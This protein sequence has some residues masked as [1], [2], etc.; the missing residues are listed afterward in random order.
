MTVARAFPFGLISAL[1]LSSFAAANEGPSI[2]APQ[3]QKLSRVLALPAGPVLG[4]YLGLPKFAAYS[5]P[6]PQNAPMA[7]IVTLFGNPE[8]LSENRPALEADLG[9]DSALRLANRIQNTRQTAEA[10]PQSILALSLKTTRSLYRQGRLTALMTG[11]TKR[12]L[13]GDGRDAIAWTLLVQSDQTRKLHDAV[14]NV[15]LRAGDG[16][17]PLSIDSGSGCSALRP[18]R[19]LGI[20]R[21]ILVGDQYD[22]KLTGDAAEQQYLRWLGGQLIAI[23]E[24]FPLQIKN[25]ADYNLHVMLEKLVDKIFRRGLA[26][27][28]PFAGQRLTEEF[29]LQTRLN[30]ISLSGFLAAAFGLSARIPIHPFRENWEHQSPQ[31]RFGHLFQKPSLL[32]VEDSNTGDYVVVS[33]VPRRIEPPN[34]LAVETDRGSVLAA[35][36][37]I[38]AAAPIPS[39]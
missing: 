36:H 27:N 14:S 39:R 16:S 34:H 21:A 37:L 4:K 12:L 20:A 10:D 25:A 6:D 30:Q 38:V 17:A 8:I 31:A 29:I 3:I 23:S 26:G 18:L 11:M 19:K 22:H 28:T 7:Y 2:L 13:G 24:R 33:G 15:L 35:S 5:Q 9:R 32:L 1:L